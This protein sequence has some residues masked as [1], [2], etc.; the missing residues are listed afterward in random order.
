[1]S[2]WEKYYKLPLRLDPSP[3]SS[4]AWGEDDSMVLG[5]SNEISRE[6]VRYIIDVINGDEASGFENL[7]FSDTEFFVEDKYIC[8]I[9]GWGNLTGIGG[10][11]LTQ[12]EAEEIHMDFRDFIYHQ[13]KA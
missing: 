4:Y 5:F 6:E 9:R 2:K 1:M 3:Y 8:E 11:D 7:N 10:H 12:E 13:L